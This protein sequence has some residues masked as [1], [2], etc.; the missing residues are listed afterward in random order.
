MV[1]GAENEVEIRKIDPWSAGKIYA[2]ICAIMGFVYGLFMGIILIAVGNMTFAGTSV[3]GAVS[4]MAVSGT[5]IAVIGFL[6]VI[7][8]PVIGAVAGLICGILGAIVYNFAAGKVG[9]IKIRLK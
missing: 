2:V 6:F 9:G 4:P 1:H 3:A 5:G 8:S 7:C